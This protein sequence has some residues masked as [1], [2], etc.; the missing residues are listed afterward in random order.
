MQEDADTTRLAARLYFSAMSYL[1]GALSTEYFL[2]E[3]EYFPLGT[4][5]SHLNP[6][7]ITQPKHSILLAPDV[8]DY[9]L[10]DEIIEESLDVWAEAGRDLDPEEIGDMF[11]DYLLPELW[12]ATRHVAAGFPIFSDGEWLEIIYYLFVVRTLD[13]FQQFVRESVIA[14]SPF[15]D[16]YTKFSSEIDL[17]K[18]V[19]LAE[20]PSPSSLSENQEIAE[21]IEGK[22]R[23]FVATWA[24][25]IQEAATSK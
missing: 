11:S 14:S 12:K 1:Y 4:E 20:L 17:L 23:S 10:L 18:S 19:L 9:K 8:H 22:L 5:Y 24:E 16:R 6:S 25:M 21:F 7:D 3:T 15:Y 2:F 13:R